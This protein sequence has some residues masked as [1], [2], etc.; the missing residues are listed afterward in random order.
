MNKKQ[1]KTI[2]LL[3]VG[4]PSAYGNL[5]ARKDSKRAET[6]Y[7]HYPEKWA[8]TLGGVKR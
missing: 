5:K 1:I 3:A 6:Y 4:I 2:Y 8:D 7:E